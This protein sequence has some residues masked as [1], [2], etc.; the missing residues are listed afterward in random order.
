[1]NKVFLFLVF[2]LTVILCSG[3]DLWEYAKV[4]YKFV[5]F[6]IP[7]DSKPDSLIFGET[8][9]YFWEHPEFS[10]SFDVNPW[11]NYDDTILGQ[12]NDSLKVWKF[13][14]ILSL[15]RTRSKIIFSEFKKIGKVNI[16]HIRYKTFSRRS[17]ILRKQF[18][19]TSIFLFIKGSFKCG[20]A[21]SCKKS[22]TK[23]REFY[24]VEKRF[25]E[26]LEFR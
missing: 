24:D 11:T 25:I 15:L 20:F 10:F 26:S 2:F 14:N 16:C 3:Q 5:S 19:I 7:V 6:K 1:M 13:E 23:F 8:H 18:S 12:K 22:S 21:I 9:I 4:P 17:C